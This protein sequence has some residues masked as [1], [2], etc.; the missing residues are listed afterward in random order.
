MNEAEVQVRLVQNP[1]DI[2]QLFPDYRYELQ[3]TE[4]SQEASQMSESLFEFIRTNADIAIDDTT[5]DKEAYVKGFQRAVAI[6]RLW[7]DS[8]YISKPENPTS[9]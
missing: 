3:N 1:I 6:A 2:N 8:M 5:S 9:I 7:I 4:V